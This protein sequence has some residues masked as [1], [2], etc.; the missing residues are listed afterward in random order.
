[1]RKTWIWLMLMLLPLRIWAGTFMP[2]PM[3]VVWPGPDHTA[4]MA[5]IQ[6][7]AA[8]PSLPP[9]DGTHDCHGLLAQTPEAQHHHPS[10][11]PDP[12]AE[13]CHDGPACLVCAVCHLSAGMPG[14]PPQL[15][16]PAP[17]NAPGTSPASLRGHAWPPLIKP[18][19][20]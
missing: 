2:M 20:A 8:S 4:R 15:L 5:L 9:T 16:A 7:Q 13:D 1:M 17:H 19:I 3:P 12:I 18:P 6:S 11:A 14:Q 10:S